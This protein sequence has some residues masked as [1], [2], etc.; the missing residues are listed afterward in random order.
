MSSGRRIEW[1]YLP[2]SPL[3]NRYHPPNTWV[4]CVRFGI[5]MSQSLSVSDVIAD[6][7]TLD[8]QPTTADDK[9]LAVNCKK[10]W[11]VSIPTPGEA[12]SD[13]TW[14]LLGKELLG[15]S[16]WHGKRF[17]IRNW[18][19]ESTY[20]VRTALKAKFR[21]IQKPVDP[22]VLLV[23]LRW[24]LWLNGKDTRT[25]YSMLSDQAPCSRNTNG[26]SYDRVIKRICNPVSEISCKL[27]RRMSENPSITSRSPS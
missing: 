9:L 2:H 17:I 7:H 14:L 24:C 19:S 21:D 15:R 1:R 23:C 20:Q 5:R 13:K 3:I 18:A 10:V 6:V 22:F 11:R 12:L 25:V 27:G 16:P 26:R 4:N 8:H